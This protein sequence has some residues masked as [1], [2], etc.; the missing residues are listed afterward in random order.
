MQVWHEAHTQGV[1]ADSRTSFCPNCSNAIIFRGVAVICSDI[2]HDPAQVPHWKHLLKFCP[3]ISLAF[4]CNSLSMVFGEIFI[5]I[6]TSYE[7]ASVFALACLQSP[8]NQWSMTA[9]SCFFSIRQ[10]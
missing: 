4:R 9:V 7:M 2:G 1:F 8:A 5:G 6:E 3:L 10:S